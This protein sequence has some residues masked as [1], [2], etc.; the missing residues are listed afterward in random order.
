M[1]RARRLFVKEALDGIE[2]GGGCRRKVEGPPR[3]RLQPFA[4]LRVF[5]GGVVI[6]DCMDMLAG[7]YGCF[8]RVEEADILLV[9][10]LLH[11][12]AN[13]FS[14][15]HVEGCKQR[16]RAMPLVVVRHRAAASLF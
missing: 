9:P 8:D 10:V 15:E 1:P 16:R 14:V 12:A 3:M 11:A 13:N 4:H 5:V 7:R 6:D 2:P